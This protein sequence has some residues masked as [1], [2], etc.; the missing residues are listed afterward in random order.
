[1]AAIND[2]SSTMKLRAGPSGSFVSDDSVPCGVIVKAAATSLALSWGEGWGEGAELLT[3]TN[4]GTAA[5]ADSV[6]F[7]STCS[8]CAAPPGNNSGEFASD[9]G[10]VVK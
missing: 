5:C 3:N 8:T 10:S 1:M 4:F 6:C 7:D 2:N 9:A